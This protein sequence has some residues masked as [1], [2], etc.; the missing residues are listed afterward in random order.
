[1]FYAL[2][3]GLTFTIMIVLLQL[4]FGDILLGLLE[5]MAKM[6]F[7]ANAMVDQ[8]IANLPQQM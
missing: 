5:L 2:R 7:V 6:I 4:F 3:V 8:V 1:M